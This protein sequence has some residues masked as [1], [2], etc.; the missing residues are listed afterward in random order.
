MTENEKCCTCTTPEYTI[1]LNKQGPQ[2]L[3]GPQGEPGFSPTIG[4]DTDTSTTY[5]LN[6]TTADGSFNTPNLKA[7]IPSGGNLGQ[8]LTRVT[9]GIS[10]EYIPQATTSVF[11]GGYLATEDDITTSNNKLVS[12]GLLADILATCVRTSGNQT[13][14][15]YK[16]FTNGVSV[17]SLE[18]NGN[19]YMTMVDRNNTPY[20]VFGLQ[21]SNPNYYFSMGF[22][23]YPLQLKS[24][25]GAVTVAR[26]SNTYTMIDSGNISGYLPTKTSDLTNDSGFITSSD[27]PTVGNGTITLTQGGVTKGTFTTN[28]SGNA[29]ISLDAGGSSL[30]AGSGIDITSDVI[31]VNYDST[32]GL[33]ATNNALGVRV[34]GTTIDFDAS[35]N[36]KSIASAPS[37]M[38][39]TDTNQTITGL[40]IFDSQVDVHA[41]I[42]ARYGTSP[43]R[44]VFNP[45]LTGA[46]LDIYT[47]D[48]QSGEIG[49]SGSDSSRKMWIQP[50]YNSTAFYI[51]N[52][53]DGSSSSGIAD[54]VVISGNNVNIKRSG[55]TYVNIDSGNISSYLPTINGGNATNA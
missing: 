32:K 28:Q 30:T 13:V 9:D 42:I 51:N 25:G 19:R 33:V 4:V 44:V 26:N 29:T 2:G 39:T 35:G 12:G 11:G 31:S 46:Q 24:S 37:N 23:N 41:D 1:K 54:T 48:N 16:T 20:E 22:S 14:G 6:I 7:T 52:Y 43:Q 50:P 45:T 21:G 15:G 38:V 36:L 17:G 3:T 10:W 53:S 5:V 49:V 27:L 40:K 55:Q 34:D 18:L 47:T 8:V